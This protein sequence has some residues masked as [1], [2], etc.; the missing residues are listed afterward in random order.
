MQFT[1]G[2]RL[3]KG[4]RSEENSDYYGIVLNMDI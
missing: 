3:L 4:A 2:H 1:N